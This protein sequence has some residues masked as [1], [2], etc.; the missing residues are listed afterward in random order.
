MY[1]KQSYV[2]ILTDLLNVRTKDWLSRLYPLYMV[3][4]MAQC[5]QGLIPNI[6][7]TRNADLPQ[8]KALSLKN[9][10]D[11]PVVS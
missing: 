1:L 9:V 10:M 11:S 6:T 3:V 5:V 4:Q 7:V 2:R 8:V